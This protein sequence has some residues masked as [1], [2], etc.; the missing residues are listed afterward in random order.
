MSIETRYSLETPEQVE[1][2]FE[3][4]GPGSRF[5]AWLIDAALI[6]LMLVGLVVI[7]VALGATVSLVDGIESR[8][9]RL[10]WAL[11]VI[12]AFVITT[13]YYILS[14][15][16]LRGQTW[17][18]RSMKL[19]VIRD[20]ATPITASESVVRN[21]IRIVDFLPVF[22]GLGGIICLVHPRH[23]RLGDLAAGTVVVK[24]SEADY[25]AHADRKAP[26][27]TAESGGTGPM[28]AEL[29]P[30]ERHALASFM[31]RRQELMPEARYALAERLAKPLYQKY[32][33]RWTDAEGYLQHLAE[34]THHQH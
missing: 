20:D 30:T 8:A 28:N 22:Y 14:E 4:A 9:S 5:C 21:L 3:L 19:R 33:G 18:K 17:G 13:G 25:R 29:T 11:V 16:L 24:E 23:K 27:L 34:G 15:M 26:V 1:L 32:G 7:A 31:A 6:G 2:E 10:A 12:A